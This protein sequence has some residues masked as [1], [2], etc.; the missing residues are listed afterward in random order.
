VKAKNWPGR[1]SRPARGQQSETA[2]S[3][4]GLEASLLRLPSALDRCASPGLL[5]VGGS[6]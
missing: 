6:R 1:L 5:R 2:L 3:A 4:A